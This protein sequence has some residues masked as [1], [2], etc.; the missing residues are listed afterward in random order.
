[1]GLYLKFLSFF[2]L[3]NVNKKTPYNSMR[4]LNKSITCMI[5][6]KSI[7]EAIRFSF[8]SHKEKLSIP[9]A[10]N[11]ANDL[12]YLRTKH[13]PSNIVKLTA[14][15]INILVKTGINLFYKMGIKKFENLE[16]YKFNKRKKSIYIFP[17]FFS[18]S[19]KIDNKKFN[20]CCIE[21]KKSS[22]KYKRISKKHFFQCFRYSS[23]SRKPV[24]L[25]YLF[26]NKKPK[27][28]CIYL[29]FPKIFIIS[30]GKMSKFDI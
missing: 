2:C 8:M 23:K 12:Y 30:N 3:A 13:M 1:M 27:S 28:K 18:K 4:M 7:E 5:R 22:N 29:V 11:Y 26:F 25:T 24:I 14:D 21:L 9:A 6:G 10:Q 17:D 19:V 20:N 16:S 15:P